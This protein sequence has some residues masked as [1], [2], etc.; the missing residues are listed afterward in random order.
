[1]NH[2]SR[3]ILVS[4]FLA[5]AILFGAQ[6][7]AAQTGQGIQVSPAVIED[8][9]KPG[10][11]Y[12]FTFTFT[13]IGS[14]DRTF[15]LSAQD[16]KGL[17]DTGQPI[18]AAPGEATGYELSSWINLSTAPITLLAGQS[19]TL[20]LVA[21]VPINVSPGVHFGGIFI[22]DQPPKLSTNGSGVG[23]SVGGIMSLTVAGNTV[24]TAK[25]QEFSTDKVVYSTPTVTFDSKIQNGG[26]V[27]VSPH[28]IIQITDMFGRKVA[29]VYINDTAAPVFPA[30]ERLYT[31]TWTATGLSF[32][33][34]EAI[35]SFS[36]G[37]TEKKTISGATS[38]WILPWK[39]I[40]LFLGSIIGVVL[41][42]YVSIRMYIR[43]KLREMGISSTSRADVN[44]YSQKYQRSGSR[45]IVVTLVIFLFCVV[46]LSVLFFVF[47]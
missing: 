25:L 35:G 12:S 4:T 41:L 33:L 18:F 24:E 7:A 42:M 44:F 38:F 20:N 32:G 21:Q 13:N 26:N 28:G 47:A 10:E 40:A 29:I 9:V 15:Y 31:T 19:T 23:M 22:T 14:A 3:A 30:S 2:Q 46:F 27:L 37:D 1:M 45:L 6:Y 11:L 43:K 5:V 39:P 17:D 8:N 36:Y 34:F 16:I